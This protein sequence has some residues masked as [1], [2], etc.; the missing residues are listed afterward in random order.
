MK[1]SQTLQSVELDRNLSSHKHEEAD[2]RIFLRVRE[3]NEKAYLQTVVVSRDT[4]VLILAY[5]PQLR[6]WM[7]A[8]TFK[9]Q[10]FVPVNFNNIT[11]SQRALFLAFHA[12]TGSN[13]SNHCAGIGKQS[14]WSIF[15]NSQLLQKRFFR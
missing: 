4:D 3:A 15:Q 12:A 14:A 9:K 1:D 7:I 11:D 2:T 10:I 13:S 8:K 5:Q 6:L